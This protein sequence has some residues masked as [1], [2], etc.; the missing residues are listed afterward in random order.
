MRTKLVQAPRQYI[1]TNFATTANF[2]TELETSRIKNKF[3]NNRS[4][5]RPLIPG[6]FLKGPYIPISSLL[7]ISIACGTGSSK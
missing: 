2:P 1:S 6:N 7:R 5:S 3:E 4:S